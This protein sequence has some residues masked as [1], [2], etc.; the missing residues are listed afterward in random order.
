MASD[1]ELNS[2]A[3][4]LID[5]S[6]NNHPE[7]CQQTIFGLRGRG[8]MFVFDDVIEGVAVVEWA[9]F[10]DDSGIVHE[11]SWDGYQLER[12]IAKEASR[13]GLGI[14][15]KDAVRVAEVVR[16]LLPELED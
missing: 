5:Q 13:R 7:L 1:K 15:D 6:D 9:P 12:Y 3:H 10:V 11:A 4:D 16:L 8:Y 2:F 14:S